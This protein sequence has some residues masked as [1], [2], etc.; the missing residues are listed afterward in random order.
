MTGN[1]NLGAT[2]ATKREEFLERIGKIDSQIKAIRSG[3]GECNY[4]LLTHV[5]D[6]T[7]ASGLTVDE[8]MEKVDTYFRDIKH[9]RIELAGM[10]TMVDKE[11]QEQRRSLIVPEGIVK[12]RN[13]PEAIR[14]HSPESYIID[15]VR[16]RLASGQAIGPSAT[17]TID[18]PMSIAGMLQKAD[19]TRSEGWMPESL[20]TPGDVVPQAY[21]TP[22]LI[23]LIPQDTTDQ[24][25][26]RWMLQ[27]TRMIAPSGQERQVTLV[28]R[29]RKAILTATIS[30]GTVGSVTVLDGGSGYESSTPLISFSGPGS[31][32]VAT[33]TVVSGVITAVTV[34]AGGTGYTSAPQVMVSAPRMARQATLVWTPQSAEVRD[35]T[36]F[37]PI[38][39]QVLEDAPGVAGLIRTTLR[40]MLIEDTEGLMFDGQGGQNFTSYLNAAGVQALTMNKSVLSNI[41]RADL[42][43]Q[44]EATIISVGKT[45]PTHAVMNPLVWHRLRTI[46]ATNS[47]YA[48]GSPALSPSKMIWGMEVI[49]TT[50]L[51]NGDDQWNALVGN[52]IAPWSV[53]VM[54]RGIRIEMGTTGTQFT[55]QERTML[56]THRCV[57]QIRRAA[58]FGK[59]ELFSTN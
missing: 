54:R 24:Q 20:R 53:L 43:S 45:M 50:F 11:E 29:G 58:A 4:A 35:I 32:A 7:L 52:F 55:E 6:E 21:E 46:R 13:L 39:T 23:G 9:R 59:M 28:G 17:L 33:A 51:G 41:D 40:E 26:V 37:V 19:F 44:M 8:K 34:S 3:D 22:K 30:S 31:G 49:P 10:E 56:A 5:G 16:K 42:F 1:A 38:T 15:Q 25:H 2:L 12:A 57:L 27:T 47:N 36:T 14:G 48:Y 18:L